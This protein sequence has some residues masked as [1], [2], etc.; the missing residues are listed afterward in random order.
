VDAIMTQVV[1]RSPGSVLT[2]EAASQSFVDQVARDYAS[3]NGIT[4]ISQ[5][6]GTAAPT[7]VG[8]SALTSLQTLVAL[9]LK[10]PSAQAVAAGATLKELFV[11]QS[12]A[13]L[14]KVLDEIAKEFG[15]TP[16][17]V[18]D[19]RLSELA[20]LLDPAELLHVGSPCR[21]RRGHERR[22]VAASLEP[23]RRQ[24]LGDA[25]VVP[26]GCGELADGERE[27]MHALVEKQMTTIGRVR[28]VLEPEHVCGTEAVGEVGDR[29]RQQAGSAKSLAIDHEAS[30]GTPVGQRRCGDAVVVAP[31]IDGLVE[32]LGEAVNTVALASRPIGGEHQPIRLDDPQPG[33]SRRRREGIDRLGASQLLSGYHRPCRCDQEH[34]H[35]HPDRVAHVSQFIQTT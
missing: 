5:S 16:A 22:R 18:A 29:R 2:T 21:D 23:V 28:L 11:G 34:G 30:E 17:N 12:A 20:K 4:L 7:A 13:V 3:A 6:L 26:R 14:S 19:L 32:D 8:I 1:L 15:T 9:E 33:P 24:H 10:L 25:L 35:D 31:G 27:G